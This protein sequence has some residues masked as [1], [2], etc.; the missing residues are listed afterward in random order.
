M[1]SSSS[2][3]MDDPSGHYHQGETRHHERRAWGRNAQLLHCVILQGEQALVYLRTNRKNSFSIS[4]LYAVHV[5][6]F[7][8]VATKSWSDFVGCGTKT[9]KDRMHTRKKMSGKIL[10]REYI[11]LETFQWNYALYIAHS[12]LNNGKTSIQLYQEPLAV[13]F[14]Q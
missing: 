6:Q 14:E 3:L 2:Q 12:R 1:R 11:I 10:C 9:V 5:S 7:L 4:K 13:V 8:V